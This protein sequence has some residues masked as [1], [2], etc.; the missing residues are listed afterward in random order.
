[1]AAFILRR[2]A[3]AVVTIFG[4]MIVTFLLFRVISGDIA[5][6]HVGAKAT[7]QQ[8][9]DWRHM[10]GY[11]RP[12]LLNLHRQLLLVDRTA[13]GGS[14]RV[15]DVKGGTMAD[16]LALIPA[17]AIGAED[18]KGRSADTLMGRYVCR[19]SPSTPIARLTAGMS[20]DDEVAAGGASFFT[21]ATAAT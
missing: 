4:V 12:L 13:G 10:Y 6:M 5:A 9:A 14:F 3:Q 2:L 17:D 16:S 11:D 18:S 1:M 19:L 21:F 7:E 20:G 15:E 8:K